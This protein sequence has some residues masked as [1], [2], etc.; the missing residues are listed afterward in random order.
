MS[1]DPTL[2]GYADHRFSWGEHICG[3]YDDPQQQVE[4]VVPFLTQGLRAGQRCV[5]ASNASAAERV[6]Q[7]LV[8]GG[9]D[10]PTLEAS[11]QLV[12]LTDVEFY[13]KDGLFVPERTLALA[14][15]LLEDGQRHGY[16]EMRIAGDPSWLQEGA[17]DFE[18]WEAYEHEAT[19]RISELPVVVLCQYD[20]RRFPGSHIVTALLTHPVVIL[21]DNLCRNPYFVPSA[22]AS[23]GRADIC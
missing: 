16:H 14:A 6:R 20:R 11:G 17:L 7:G 12:I 2:F 10:L 18:A 22:E 3:I 9:C 15:A 23:V 4:V 5:W 1:V 21:G 8:K 13:L 19:R